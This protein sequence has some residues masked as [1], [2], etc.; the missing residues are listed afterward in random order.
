MLS[1]ISTFLSEIW[2]VF[3]SASVPGFSFTF[4]QLFLASMVVSV[5]GYALRVLLKIEAC[6]NA[7][8]TGKARRDKRRAGRALDKRMA[9]RRKGSG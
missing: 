5:I 8:R 2:K 4:A 1:Y 3:Q 9:A 7:Y 6:G